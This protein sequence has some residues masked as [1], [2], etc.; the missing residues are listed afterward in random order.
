[1]KFTAP[2]NRNLYPPGYYMLF[3]VNERGQPSIAKMVRL[4][5]KV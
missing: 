4:H 3:Y 5:E 2:T 1:M